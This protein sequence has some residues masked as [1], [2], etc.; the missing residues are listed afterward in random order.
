MLQSKKKL[1]VNVI[2]ITLGGYLRIGT[3]NTTNQWPSVLQP[4]Y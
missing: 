2:P 1:Q 3:Q 4:H